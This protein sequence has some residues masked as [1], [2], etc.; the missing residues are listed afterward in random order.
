[1]MKKLIAIFGDFGKQ[2]S[3]D[4]VA[5]FASSTAFFFFLSLMPMLM[6]VCSV[7]PY[8]PLTEENLLTAITRL[9]PD[10]MDPLMVSM[11]SQV[12]DM[13]SN[14]LPIAIIVTIWSAGKGM[15]AL[16]RGLN[17][18]NGVV[19]NRNYF[20]LRLEASFYTVITVIALILSLGFSVFG[21]ILIHTIAN[22][23]PRISAFLDGIV[24]L[25]FIF[26]WMFLAFA[27]TLI[28]TFLPN[29]KL[30]L[31]YQL[32]GAIFASITWSIFSF[33]FSIYVDDFHGMSTYGSLS[34]IVLIMVWLYSCI[35]ILLIGAN[36]NRYF[37]PVIH[38]IMKKK[39]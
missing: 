26:V 36:M 21:K 18:V 1:M 8:T 19:E 23:L 37:K 6:I 5:A 33:A 30:K 39:E 16:M 13:Y 22:D 15:L 2:M 20:I 28:Y 7:I 35:S 27:F 3:R 11:V 38:V 14:V 10:S 12:Y 4:N 24:H 9:T 29:K 31:R 25:R 34:T 17:A 32:P